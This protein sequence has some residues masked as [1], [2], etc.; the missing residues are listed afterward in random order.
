ME[1]IVGTITL[2][3]P[4]WPL[5]RELYPMQSHNFA[6]P[7][8]GESGWQLINQYHPSTVF[9]NMSDTAR[10]EKLGYS[11]SIQHGRRMIHLLRILFLHSSFLLLFKCR[12]VSTSVTENRITNACLYICYVHFL[13]LIISIQV[14]T[15]LYVYSGPFED[16]F[17][18]RFRKARYFIAGNFLFLWD[19]GSLD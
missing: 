14:S 9:N 19:F 7:R 10:S 3:C 16:H 1:R 6:A 13:F 18:M 2:F 8:Q 15:G 5:F 17:I 12:C 11:V 4:F